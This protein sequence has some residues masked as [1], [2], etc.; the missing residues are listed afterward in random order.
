MFTNLTLVCSVHGARGRPAAPACLRLVSPR[1]GARLF[2]PTAVLSTLVQRLR[3]PADHG[4]HYASLSTTATTNAVAPG[5]PGAAHKGCSKK[6][7]ARSV[8]QTGDTCRVY[9]LPVLS[10]LPCSAPI[11]VRGSLRASGVVSG[12]PS[13]KTVRSV[14]IWL[15]AHLCNLLTLSARLGSPEV[16]Q[17]RGKVLADLMSLALPPPASVGH[18]LQSAMSV[19]LESG[20]E[21]PHSTFPGVE[22]TSG[23]ASF[24]PAVSD[25][26][27]LTRR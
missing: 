24:T 4:D 6:K 9:R 2:S 14:E 17:Y 19:H 20:S 18:A 3:T 7:K 21:A 25:L 23:T 1:S 8:L 16:H 5:R 10:L 13:R 22:L 11:P 15:Q 12:C 26:S 27:K